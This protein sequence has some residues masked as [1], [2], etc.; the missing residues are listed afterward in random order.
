MSAK[1]GAIERLFRVPSLGGQVH[2]LKKP[3]VDTK[4]LS[5]DIKNMSVGTISKV[6]QT[7]TWPTLS[8]SP[9]QAGDPHNL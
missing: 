1:L 5:V 9:P 8:A 4:K 6:D 2:I 7:P 3:S